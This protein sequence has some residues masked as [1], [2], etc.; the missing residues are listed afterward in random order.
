MVN[1]TSSASVADVSSTP[2]ASLA[3]VLKPLLTNLA[4]KAAEKREQEGLEAVPEADSLLK[5]WRTA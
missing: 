2:E 5:G 1:G 3:G 4:A